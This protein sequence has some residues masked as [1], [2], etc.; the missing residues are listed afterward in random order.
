MTTADPQVLE[1]ALCKAN[2]IQFN[3]ERPLHSTRV[4][5]TENERE[6]D[7]IFSIAGSVQTYEYM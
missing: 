3:A 6:V 2:Q 7:F 1:Q 4:Q 5:S